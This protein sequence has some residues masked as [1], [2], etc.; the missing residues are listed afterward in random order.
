MIQEVTF[1]G[2]SDQMLEQK[3]GDVD[4]METK[5]SANIVYVGLKM[6]KLSFPHKNNHK[7]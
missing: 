7:D 5:C 6:M 2:K 4:M 3:I 1:K